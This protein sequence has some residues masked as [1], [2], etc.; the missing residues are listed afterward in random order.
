MEERKNRSGLAWLGKIPLL[1]RLF[2]KRTRQFNQSDLVLSIRPRM[3]RLP[4][5]E[6]GP[7]LTFRFGPEQRPLPA[8]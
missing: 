2:R 7:S 8:L 4:P 1:G 3:V 6:L 5:A